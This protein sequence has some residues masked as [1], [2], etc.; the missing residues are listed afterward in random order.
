VHQL[1]SPVTVAMLT[2][3]HQVQVAQVAQALV[4]MAAMVAMLQVD[5]AATA[6]RLASKSEA[7]ATIT[8]HNKQK[9]QQNE[10]LIFFFFF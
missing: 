2:V 10:I 8:A 3:L 7:V 1:V 5:Q 9:I 6:V 4:A